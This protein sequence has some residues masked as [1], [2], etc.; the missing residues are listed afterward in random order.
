MR[1]PKV[2][3]SGTKVAVKKATPGT[4]R[5]L[6]IQFQN[7]MHVALGGNMFVRTQ[8]EMH[9]LAGGGITM[10]TAGEFNL[11]AGKRINIETGD[12]F[13]RKVKSHS[14]EEVGGKKV[15]KVADVTHLDVSGDYHVKSGGNINRDAS[16]LIN[17]NSGQAKPAPPININTILASPAKPEGDRDT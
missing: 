2:V 4:K 5:N 1:P 15:T 16:P 17:D 13:N 9:F 10:S 8:G 12:E 6:E 3:A 14:V 11:F 7:D